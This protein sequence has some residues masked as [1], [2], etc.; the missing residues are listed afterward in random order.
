MK[1][2]IVL[3]ILI[4]VA[5][6]SVFA[7]DVQLG[8]MQNLV[9]T[10]FLVDTEFDH[11]GFEAA[12]GVP[13]V[14]MVAGGVGAIVDAASDKAEATATES[15]SESESESKNT[16]NWSIVTGAMLNLYWKAYEGEKFSFRLGIQ[17]DALGFFGNKGYNFFFTY[18]PSLGFNYKFNDRFAMNFTGTVPAALILSPFGNDLSSN[19]GSYVAT[20]IKAED[21]VEAFG[22]GVLALFQ[23]IGLFGSEVARVSFKWSV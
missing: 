23:G 9:N 18:G 22:M 17:G 19:Y 12:V 10:S 11:F 4:A 20:N 1:K 21:A 3:M 13:V 5:C 15:E 14:Y 7:A 2:L 6:T 8:V 16:G